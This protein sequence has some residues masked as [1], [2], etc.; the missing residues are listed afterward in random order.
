V[1]RAFDRF[2]ADLVMT[3]LDLL[4]PPGRAIIARLHAVGA[5]VRIIGLR[6]SDRPGS[7]SVHSRLRW[8]ADH[9]FQRAL[10]AELAEGDRELNDTVG[11][12]GDRELNDTA[13]PDQSAS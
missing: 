13:G 3:D 2:L 6:R 4:A 1:R 12:E 9:R 10:R 8:W 7:R 5:Y 11:P